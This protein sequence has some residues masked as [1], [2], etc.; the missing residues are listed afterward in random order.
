MDKNSL[1]LIEKFKTI[2]SKRWIPSV[3]NSWGSI[4]L[5]FEKELEKAPDSTYNPDYLD[6]EIKCYSRFS[7]YPLYLFTVAFDGPNFNEIDRIVNLYGW[8]DKD[9]PDKKIVFRKI[10]GEGY[11]DKYNFKFDID[12]KN[13]KIFLCVYTST[14]ILLER[15]SF[16]YFSSIKEHLYTKLKKL[17]IV[18]AS[19]KKQDNGA[20]FRYYKISL[21]KLKNFDVFLKLIENNILKIDLISRISKSGVDKGRYRNKN[22]VFSIYK[23]DIDKLFDCYYCSKDL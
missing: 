15:I 20:F 4:G 8:Y 16:V 17:A 7:K 1:K 10:N 3:S 2:A 9:F 22:I 13:E 18:R 19:I 5:T 23:C 11:P 14:G 6:I 21:F 12:Y